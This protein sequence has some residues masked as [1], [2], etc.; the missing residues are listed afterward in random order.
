MLSLLPLKRACSSFI[1]K[2]AMVD[3]DR[4]HHASKNGEID[5]VTW[6]LSVGISIDCTDPYGRTSLYYACSAGHFEIVKLLLEQN[7]DVGVS[8]FKL[9]YSPLHLAC[10]RG[11][12]NIAD[13][14]V[15]YGANIDARDHHGDTSLCRSEY[16]IAE[17]LL[18]HG[19]DINIKDNHDNTPLHYVSYWG[20]IDKLCLFLSHG[21]DG[22]IRNHQNKTALDVARS[23]GRME[24]VQ[25]LILH[26]SNFHFKNGHSLLHEALIN[27]SYSWM[28]DVE[29]IIN[30][31]FPLLVERD[32]LTGLYPFQLA[33]TRDN[34][35]ES[36]YELLRRA[37]F[38]LCQRDILC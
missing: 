27:E 37:P 36:G 28:R 6:F 14:L 19:A 17:L 31:N 11:F 21:A 32:P 3:R 13:I 16:K 7:A 25:E 4:I 1:E 18:N 34:D 30:A 5:E 29:S 2:I 10:R 9:G 26:C 33:G 38:L 8:D 35:L 24:I 15:K 20:Q 23:R 22:T 12:I